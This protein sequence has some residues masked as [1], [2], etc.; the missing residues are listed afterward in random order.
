MSAARAAHARSTLAILGSATISKG[1]HP[2]HFPGAHVVKLFPIVLCPGTDFVRALQVPLGHIPLLL[3]S[4]IRVDDVTQCFQEANLFGS[5]ASLTNCKLPHV[6]ATGL[7][8]YYN[9][10]AKF[11]VLHGP[12]TGAGV[13]QKLWFMII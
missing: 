1:C 5:S 9:L 11:T 10:Y 4:R 13:F 3:N 7:G 8:N 12:A 2:C 6:S